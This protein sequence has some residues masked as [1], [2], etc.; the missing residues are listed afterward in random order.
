MKRQITKLILMSLA[1][2]YLVS[3]Q[4][5][6][7]FFQ[8]ETFGLKKEKV[9]EKEDETIPS[10]N[11]KQVDDEVPVVIEEPAID[12]EKSPIPIIQIDRFLMSSQEIKSK[13]DILWVI[14]NSGSMADN[15]ERLAQNFQ[16][17]AK[18]FVDSD[19]DFKMA[20]TTTSMSCSKCEELKQ[21]G[22]QVN[23]IGSLTLA[24][25]KEN[26]DQFVSDFQ[27][28]ISVGTNGSG[29]EQALKTMNRF[30]D[31]QK[32]TD[33][34]RED[35]YTLV[36]I[37]SDE[38]AFTLKEKAE[39]LFEN[40]LMDAKELELKQEICQIK[41]NWYRQEYFDCSEQQNDDI[42]EL[43]KDFKQQEIK[44]ILNKSEN[45]NFA[46]VYVEQELSSL[47]A[48]K[49]NKNLAK[50]HSIVHLEAPVQPEYSDEDK[51]RAYLEAS[52]VTGGK[53]I[54]LTGDFSDSLKDLGQGIVELSKSFLLTKVP[55]S[56]ESVSVIVD[57]KLVSS[58]SYTLSL[59]DKTILFHDD[60]LPGVGSKIEVKYEI[61][62]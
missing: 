30:L 33:F 50:V 31:K 36:I 62:E 3:C 24:K 55:L 5:D 44:R 29:S 32:Y 21:D 60:A 38:E 51:A 22:N 23:P 57:G 42:K 19:I 46:K 37:L 28:Y 18:Y 12:D 14:D 2:T 58:E 56:L 43:L 17:L 61:K 11:S 54:S 53:Q 9:A 59:E 20:I 10:D 25:A 16:I 39:N 13:F 49:P 8:K 26:K 40:G 4:Q 6:G 27:Q 48:L 1:L 15:Q 7:E 52:R 41:E 45:A 35:A 47:L 34:F